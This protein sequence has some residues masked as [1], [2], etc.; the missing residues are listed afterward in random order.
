MHTRSASSW[1]AAFVAAIILT[2]ANAFSDEPPPAGPQDQGDAIQRQMEASID[3]YEV[4]PSADAQA[5]LKPRVAIRWRNAT[6]GEQATD[7]LML[8]IHDGRPTAAATVFPWEG[9]L[10]YEF[11]SLSRVAGLVARDS[12][13]DAVVWSPQ[14]AGVEFL[15]IPDA[16]M[17]A[18]SPAARLRQ[19]KSLA[20]RF[21]V[22]LT[23]W[24]ANPTREELR[25]LPRSLY[26]YE[27]TASG[28]SHP[29]LHDGAL[30][31]F[32]Q[33]TDPEALLLLEAVSAADAGDGRARWEYAF[34]RATSGGLEARLDGKQVW[35]VEELADDNAMTNPQVV[36]RRTLQE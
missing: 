24:Q 4:R 26:R 32:V 8:W 18:D 9:R 14:A 22:T 3:W 20:E 17:P 13:S 10:C 6:R 23:G 15:D 11:V 16:P 35:Q 28:Q 33:G 27:L 12:E 36:I 19:M 25:L 30:F 34:A 31:A 1:I 2:P 21:A 7:F 29:D 5:A